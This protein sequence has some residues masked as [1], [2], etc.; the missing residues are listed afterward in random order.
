MKSRTISRHRTLGDRVSGI[1]F[2]GFLI[3]IAHLSWTGQLGDKLR[4]LL[5]WLEKFF[6]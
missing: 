2:I 6:T 3:Y 1:L 5:D 4:E